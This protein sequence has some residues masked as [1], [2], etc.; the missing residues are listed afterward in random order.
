MIEKQH[1]KMQT[2][3]ENS[4]V[5]QS[6]QQSISGLDLTKN[7]AKIVERKQQQIKMIKDQFPTVKR[8]QVPDSSRQADSEFDPNSSSPIKFVNRNNHAAETSHQLL[9]EVIRSQFTK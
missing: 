1:R 8:N 5:Y 9:P 4:K 2:S 3:I 7:S 6:K